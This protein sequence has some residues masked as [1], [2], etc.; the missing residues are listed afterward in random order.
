MTAKEH[1]L[2]APPAIIPPKS[3]VRLAFRRMQRQRQTGCCRA[4]SLSFAQDSREERA[5]DRAR[6]QAIRALGAECG[7]ILG[8][9]IGVSREAN[10]LSIL[11]RPRLLMY[12]LL[13]G[14]AHRHPLKSTC[15]SEPSS[16]ERAR[17]CVSFRKENI[18]Y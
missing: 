16:G 4:G 7:N 5:P 12:I 3:L 8:S 1:A 9:T 17:A 13:S 6:G 11:P 10:C 2:G 18:T 15:L 14:R